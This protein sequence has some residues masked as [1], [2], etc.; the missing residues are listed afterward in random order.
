METARPLLAEIIGEVVKEAEKECIGFALSG[1]KMQFAVRK[2]GLR[3]KSRDR[4][5]K[6]LRK[7][8]RKVINERKARKGNMFLLCFM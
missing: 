7:K 3:Y 5:Y 8:L 6:G 4:R 2:S 1:L